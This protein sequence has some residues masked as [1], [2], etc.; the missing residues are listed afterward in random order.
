MADERDPTE[1][2]GEEVAESAG[3]SFTEFVLGLAANAAHI[4]GEDDD[5]EVVAPRADL[6]TA[7]Q[8][9]DML[10][11]LQEKTR[12][13]LTQDEEKLLGSLLY[14]LRMRYLELARNQADQAT[15][16]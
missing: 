12:G 6:V 1:P 7:S 3:V 14:D 5:P 11:M 13:N 10:S 4:M 15:A 16:S 2:T 9:I 8:H